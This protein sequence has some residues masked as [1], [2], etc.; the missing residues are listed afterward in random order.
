VSQLVGDNSRGYPGG[1]NDVSPA[2]AQFAYKG[3]AAAGASQQKTIGRKRILRAQQA[4]AIN[5][6]TNEGV[7]W[8]QSLGFQFAEWY[9]D[10]PVIRS[11]EAKTIER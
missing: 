6:A 2:T 9:M 4:K 7:D 1:G 3:V 8:N 5:Q 11:D 10:R